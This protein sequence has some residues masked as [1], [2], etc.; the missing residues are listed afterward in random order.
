MG[1]ETE[2]ER[3][4][5]GEWRRR[6]EFADL[7][8]HMIG[9]GGTGMCGLAAVLLELGAR[10]SGSDRTAFADMGRLVEGGA[11]I[12]IGH[13]AD[14]LDPL[15]DLVVYSAA[16]PPDNP[17]LAS[18]R[19]RGIRAAK[20]AV[21]LG[22]VTRRRATMAVAGTH[23]KSTTSAMCAHILRVAGLDPS[24][25]FGASSKQLGG[26]GALGT[27]RSFVVEACEYDRSFHQFTPSSAAILNIELD[28][29]DCFPTV[30]DLLTA[31]AEFAK[32]VTPGGLIVCND[33][34][35]WAVKAARTGEAELQTF[36]F[37]ESA[38]WRA[39]HLTAD[40]GRYG[41]DVT[42][43]DQPILATRLSIPGL[44]NVSNALA[45]IALTHDAGADAESIAEAVRTFEGVGRRLVYRG[46]FDGITVLDD[47]AHH[48]TE[49][50]VTIQA[51]RD[52]YGPK[53]MWVVFQPHQVS[54]MKAFLQEFAVALTSADQVVVPDVY[55]ARDVVGADA[56]AVEAD[57]GTGEA[58]SC[59]TG[60]PAELVS[61]IRAAGGSAAYV[62][63]LHAVTEHVATR[64]NQGD[65]VLVMGA[66]D[67]WK[68][69]DGLV[70][71]FC[72]SN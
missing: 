65:L 15:T 16:I 25:V 57:R 35:D 66:G 52:H 69:A 8:V 56:N 3:V 38:D 18:A 32:R 37:E 34:D 14:L 12:E 29:V 55:G 13:R 9:I 41:F 21:V 54:R 4:V 6:T 7:R 26:N 51:A 50:R 68:V 39:S 62:P 64:V 48:P 19:R 60:S 70:E 31:F 33:A 46:I 44:H 67:V 2:F 27:G 63:S 53:R 71:R 45:A 72:E 28:H 42:F 36:G 10:L 43:R 22:M 24:F 58:D 23:G 40:L 5:P 49:I 17:E 20:Y 47:Y 11:R 1:M 30:D 61:R 59:E